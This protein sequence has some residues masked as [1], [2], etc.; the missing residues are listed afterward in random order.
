MHKSFESVSVPAKY[1]EKVQA[2]V[3][4]LE[5]ADEKLKKFIPCAKCKKRCLIANTV[6]YQTHWYTPPRGCTEGDYWNEGECQFVCHHCGTRNRLLFEQSYDYK[7]HCSVSPQNDTFRWTYRNLFKE[8]KD[9][10]D[11][12][13]VPGTVW[14]NNYW[15]DSL[16]KDA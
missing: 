15:I 4:A 6:L 16:K 1:A 10:Y 12:G 11:E 8:V 7:L 3:Q 13:N 2:Y 5:K 14:I 9:V